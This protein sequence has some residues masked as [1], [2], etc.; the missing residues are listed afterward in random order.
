MRNFL[1]IILCYFIIELIYTFFI[2]SKSENIFGYVIKMEYF[3]LII[4][5]ILLI[6]GI[7]LYNKKRN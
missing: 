6:V 3:R 2:S 4:I 7:Q 5:F 1:I